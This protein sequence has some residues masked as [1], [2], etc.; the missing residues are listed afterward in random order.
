MRWEG[1]G[2]RGLTENLSRSGAMISL[3]DEPPVEPGRVVEL[4]LSVPGRAEPLRVSAT[5]RWVSAMLPNTLG[6]ELV[7]EL[8]EAVL[9]ALAPTAA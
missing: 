5:V 4:E 7:E 1:G 8:A 2:A 9:A 6:L 3:E